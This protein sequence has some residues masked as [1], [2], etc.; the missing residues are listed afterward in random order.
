MSKKT[1]RIL[2]PVVILVVISVV[3]I[4][5]IPKLLSSRRHSSAGFTENMTYDVKTQDVT[6]STT[7]SGTIN[8][9]RT[10]TLTAPAAG[11]ITAVYKK[12]GDKVIAGEVIARID[13]TSY[14]SDLAQTESRYRVAVITFKTAQMTSVADLETKKEQ[15]E[16]AVSDALAT[17]QSAEVN[18][19][20]S[21][22]TSDQV[23]SGLQQQ[24]KQAQIG[25]I[26]A[27]NS[28]KSLQDYDTSTQQQTLSDLSVTQAQLNLSNA[29][30]RLVTLTTATV[31][32]QTAIDAQ[33][34]SIDASRLSLQNAQVNSQ[35]TATT[36]GQGKIQIDT[37]T[38]AV[39]QVQDSLTAANNNLAMK[40]K[41]I[42]AQPNDL[43]VLQSNVEQAKSSVT[44]ARSNLA[45]FADTQKKSDLQLQA[46][47]EQEDQALLTL[48]VQKLL[49]DNYVVK[50][51]WSGVITTIGVAKSDM[52]TT[53]TAVAKITDQA[54]W[55]ADV[56]IDE[57]NV[58]RIKA[59]QN[60]SVT[61]DSYGDEIFHGK[62]VYVGY[63]LASSSQDTSPSQGSQS[64]AVRYMAKIQLIDPPAALMAGMK[65]DASIVLSVA[66]NVPAVPVES[67]I[68]DNGRHYVVIVSAT[69]G[70]DRKQTATQTRKEVTVGIASDDYIQIVSGLK[71]GDRILRN[72]GISSSSPQ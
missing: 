31:P 64:A 33:L 50:A 38:L 61:M 48:N 11:E 35:M 58:V 60:A 46:A 16:S 27:Q 21:K 63:A 54:K 51:P 45:A 12:E 71:A 19:Q 68:S 69:T 23:I 29:E 66:K 2:V 39:V 41:T 5:V 65:C 8:P 28:L 43:E 25:L 72:A 56:Y 6:A 62:I 44:L 30:V 3:A 40:Q 70:A 26:N 22:D 14:Q 57:T 13:D 18:L 10:A 7:V 9:A 42:G 15:L 52:V 59:D 67:V 37:A 36:I 53:S 4:I 47:K 17:Q 24:V 34:A 49:S 1:R 55:N 32:D 20:N